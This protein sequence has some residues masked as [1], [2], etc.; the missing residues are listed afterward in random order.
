MAS[1]LV[2]RCDRV[3]RSGLLHPLYV[4]RM[5]LSPETPLVP[6]REQRHEGNQLALK[7][8]ASDD[9]AHCTERRYCGK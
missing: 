2:A 7:P 5:Q 3:T 8:R 9:Y 4:S 1:I 6:T